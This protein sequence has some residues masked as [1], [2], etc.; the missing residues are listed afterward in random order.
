M[1]E[2]WGLHR[3]VAEE[4]GE[5]MGMLRE[6]LLGEQLR[7]ARTQR[8]RSSSGE[9]SSGEENAGEGEERGSCEMVEMVV[10]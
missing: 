5:G 3:G 2:P 8:Y 4:V 1:R 7:G 6:A 9:E 10:S